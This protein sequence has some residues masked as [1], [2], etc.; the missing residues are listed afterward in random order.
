MNAGRIAFPAFLLGSAILS[1]GPLLVRLAD[2]GVVQ[3]A[4]W[5]LALALPA[6]LILARTV[7]GRPETAG[8]RLWPWLALAGLFFAAD[9][10]AWHLGI[11]RT[12]LANSALFANST[13]FFYPVYGY[14]VARTWPTRRAGG[15]MLLA[16]AGIGLLMGLSAEVSARHLTGD[17]LCILAAVFYTGYLV[18]MDRVRGRL[19]PW[20]ALFAATSF[21]TAALLPLALASDGRFWPHDWTP[22]LVLALG[23]QVAGQG[24]IIFA[25]PHLSPIATGLGLLIQPMLSAML[26]WIWFSERLSS[27]EALGMTAILLALVLVRLPERSAIGNASRVQK[28]A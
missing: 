24:L 3:S 10:A 22:L 18:V 7:S 11:V 12:T 13:S 6:L 26:G 14:V 15:A 1:A 16:L 19:G 9:L 17:L 2:V 28:E 21:A 25:L 8:P 20:Q 4:F 23:S 5:R 27:A